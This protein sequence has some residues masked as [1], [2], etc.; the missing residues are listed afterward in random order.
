[1]VSVALLV[2]VFA[3]FC[4]R[5]FY[6]QSKKDLIAAEQRI[7]KKAQF[8][9]ELEKAEMKKEKAR[10]SQVSAA[11]FVQQSSQKAEFEPVNPKSYEVSMMPEYAEQYDPN[12]D[13]AIF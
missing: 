13:F 11:A 10:S 2:L 12:Q 1:M 3:L 7:E 8:A 5:Y 6:Y 4:F 9:L